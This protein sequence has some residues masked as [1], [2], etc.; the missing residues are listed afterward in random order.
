M[1]YIGK[2]VKPIFENR[3]NNVTRGQIHL[4]TY[5]YFH[6]ENNAVNIGKYA[7]P[8]NNS[9]TYLEKTAVTV[10]VQSL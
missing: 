9:D 7:Y 8:K 1:T 10:F 2:V 5:S 3:E 4:K 6:F